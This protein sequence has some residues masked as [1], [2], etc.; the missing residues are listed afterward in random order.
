M[1][2]DATSFLSQPSSFQDSDFAKL[3]QEGDEKFKDVDC[4]KTNESQSIAQTSSDD[5]DDFYF[6]FD[7]AFVSEEASCS[8]INISS[9]V[10][11][12][13]D[14][15]LILQKL[16]S[17][18][19]NCIKKHYGISQVTQGDPLLKTDSDHLQASEISQVAHPTNYPIYEIFEL[20]NN[21]RQVSALD[22]SKL[23]I[24]SIK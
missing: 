8:D 16:E 15:P 19:Q 18:N 5:T 4:I 20:K 23:M 12:A 24:Y 6:M 13:N 10:I 9:L 7:K 21:T 1:Q 22:E 11:K 3:N 14:M 2:S 17:D